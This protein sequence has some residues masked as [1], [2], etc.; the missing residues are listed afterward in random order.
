VPLFAFIFAE[1]TFVAFIFAETTAHFWHHLVQ[2]QRPAVTT[3]CYHLWY[4]LYLPPLKTRW[5]LF[6]AEIAVV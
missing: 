1:T 6:V 4:T 3:A 2:V 5:R